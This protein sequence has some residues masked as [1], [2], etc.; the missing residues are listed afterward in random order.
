MPKYANIHIISLPTGRIKARFGLMSSLN[1][2]SPKRQASRRKAKHSSRPRSGLRNFDRITSQRE[3]T[4]KRAVRM[5]GKPRSARY[6]SLTAREK[7]TRERALA[8]LSDLR[9]GEGSYSELLRKHHVDAR[10]ASRY[11]GRNFLGGAG[12]KRVRASKSD[13]L[14]RE[15]MF[16]MPFGDVPFLTRNS[17]D[18]TKLSEYYRDRDKLLHGRVGPDDFES[19]WRG[20]R[21]AGKELFADAGAILGMADA[22]VLK[23]ENLYASTG[24]ER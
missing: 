10:T 22:D 2:N 8:V 13:R 17:H 6:S 24:G 23:L 11:L 20:A 3:D 19:K 9:H 18:A 14:V 1:S 21:V 16:P 7:A 4:S 15:L 12:N 5:R